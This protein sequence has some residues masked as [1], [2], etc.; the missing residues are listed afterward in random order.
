MYFVSD[1]RHH[2]PK[3]SESRHFRNNTLIISILLT[4]NIY[5]VSLYQLSHNIFGY[6]STILIQGVRKPARSNGATWWQY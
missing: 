2:K 1:S 3:N 4:G 5:K 6:V